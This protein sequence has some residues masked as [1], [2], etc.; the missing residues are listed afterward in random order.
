MRITHQNDVPVV[1][2]ESWDERWEGHDAGLLAAYARGREKGVEDPTLKVAAQAG[3]LPVL[4]W[5][6]G[7]SSQIKSKTKMGSLYYLAMWQG[8]RGDNLKIET[9]RKIRMTCTKFGVTVIFTGNM[10]ELTAN[11]IEEI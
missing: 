6:G 1:L 5:A 8:I 4:P 11:F 9:T 3:E 7:L 2:A 10:D